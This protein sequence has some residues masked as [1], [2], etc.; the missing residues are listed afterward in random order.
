MNWWPQLL[1]GRDWNELRPVEIGIACVL[2]AVSC[3]VLVFLG[4]LVW[5]AAVS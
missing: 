2:G 3:V 4:V 5:A 1:V